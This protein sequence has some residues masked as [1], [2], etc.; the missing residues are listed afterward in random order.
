MSQINAVLVDTARS[1]MDRV[2]LMLAQEGVQVIAKCSTVSAAERVIARNA[3]NIAVI[4]A[5]TATGAEFGL[6]STVKFRQPQA[7]VCLTSGQTEMTGDIV[8]YLGVDFMISKPATEDSVHAMLAAYEWE[9][10]R[11]RIVGTLR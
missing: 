7:F 5:S 8:R 11:Q 9:K 3:F 4:D 6:C 10:R 1:R 2:E